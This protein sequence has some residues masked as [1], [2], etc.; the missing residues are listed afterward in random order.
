MSSRKKRIKDE[1][2]ANVTGR[3]AFE[4][5]NSANDLAVMEMSSLELTLRRGP[6]DRLFFCLSAVF[7]TNE[8]RDRQIKVS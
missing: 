8:L 2:Q 6:N 4:G 1:R 7:A 3:D 5:E